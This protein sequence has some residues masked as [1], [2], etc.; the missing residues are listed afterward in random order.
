MKTTM[1]ELFSELGKDVKPTAISFSGNDLVKVAE[2]MD[3]KLDKL[4]ENIEAQKAP[5]ESAEAANTATE[6]KEDAITKVEPEKATEEATGGGEE[7]EE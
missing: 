7:A 3:K 6:V 4:M 5:Q 2:E 1:D